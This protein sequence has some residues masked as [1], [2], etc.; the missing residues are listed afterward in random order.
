MPD[1]L[2]NEIKND[3][4]LPEL[5]EDI[6]AG[7]SSLSLNIPRAS[8]ILKVFNGG[9]GSNNGSVNGAGEVVFKTNDNSESFGSKISLIAPVLGGNDA[10]AIEIRAGDSKNSDGGGV[11]TIFAGHASVTGNWGLIQMYAGNGGSTSGNGGD[12]EILCGGANASGVGG[13]LTLFAG[14]GA[15]TGT[16]GDTQII[17]GNGGATDGNG[18]DVILQP[19]NAG[20][21]GTDGQLQLIAPGASVYAILNM[22][23]IATTSKTF[24]FPNTTGTL[25]LTGLAGTKVYYVAD[26]SGGAVTRKL[27]FTNGILTAET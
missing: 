25:A 3:Q 18:G 7:S 21:A 23:N 13:N 9:T 6:Q 14:D 22:D 19:G 27:T 10:G 20:G 1:E 5:Y 8:G 26:T 17:G 24:T 12:V 11:I 2:Q 15:G 4:Q 16:G